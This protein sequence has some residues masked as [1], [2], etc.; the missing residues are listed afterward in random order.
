MNTSR[1]GWAGFRRDRPSLP[2][3]AGVVLA[4][5]LTG[6]ST[7][8][9]ANTS[10]NASHG[11]PTDLITASS[12]DPTQLAATA[13]KALLADVPV[14]QLPPV[15]ADTFA[16]A[17]KPLT[18]A[19]LQQLKTCLGARSCDTGHGTLTVA[20]NADFTNNPWWSVRRAEATAQAIA[21]PQVKRIIFT[22]SSSGNIAEVLSNLRSLIAQKVDIIVEDPV[23]GPAVLPAAK[24]ALTAGIAF[25]T[26]NSPLPNEATASVTTQLPYDLCAM[27][28]G[29]VQKITA[30]AGT[31][32]KSYALYTGVPGN[33]DAAEW[34]PCAE[35][36]LKA[37]G[38]Q[39]AVSGFT[40]WTPQG[41]TQ[42]AN[43]LLASGKDV[44]AMLY[45]Y[46][47]DTFLRPYIAAGKTP[48]ASFVDTANYSAFNVYDDAKKAGLKA[49]NY[50]SNGHVWYGRLGVTAGIESKLGVNVPNKVLAPVPVVGLADIQDQNVSGMPANVPL[51]TLLNPELANL[52]LSA[53]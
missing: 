27:G 42:A 14:A 28:T 16:V 22:S 38:W 19:Q 39:Q 49:E 9:G 51:P 21:Y 47:S 36:A 15:V 13:K 18:D 20:I 2:L 44:S 3:V 10:D 6:C 5:I 52:A 12:V 32:S 40:Q 24:E 4:T 48:P 7:T 43:E 37:A 33:A 26:E 46:S 29:A 41:E 34:Q 45:D 17:S 8:T 1:A 23:F 11:V 30:G 31:A 25:V 35:K 53:G 50:V